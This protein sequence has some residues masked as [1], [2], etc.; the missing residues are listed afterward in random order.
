MK[1][2]E[3]AKQPTIY[4]IGVTTGKSAIMKVFP[5]WAEALGLKDAVIRGIDIELHADPRV[6]REAVEFIKSDEHSVGALV[7]AHKLDVFSAARDLFDEFDP[8]AQA[9]HELS[10]IS[11]RDGRL[12]GH[13]KDP[14][15]SGLAMRAF[16]PP[17]FWSEHRGE[18]F[19]MGAGGSAVAIAASLIG[20]DGNRPVRITVSDLDSGRLNHFA[21]VMARMN[22]DPG[23]FEYVSADRDGVNDTVLS[24]LPSH[25]LV[26]NA[27]GLGKDRPGSP[28]S[29]EASFPAD[30]LV[31][32][33]N[34]RGDLRFLEQ[35]RRQAEE[36]RLSVHDGWIYFIHGWTQVIA[37]V[38]HIPIGEREVERLALL[39]SELH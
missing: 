1:P 29:D 20:Q 3:P 6:Y 36:K 27:T 22:A 37:E 5:K 25:S 8:Y 4:F 18:V 2:F 11:K 30:S 38:F 31:W 9:L 39:A 33:L 16:T 35:A 10:C 24:R 14:I 34:Y 21:E 13:A 28:I 7:T 17:N 12:T 26:V 15:S 19:L 32:E 23:L